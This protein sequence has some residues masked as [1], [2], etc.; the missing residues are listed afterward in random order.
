MQIFLRVAIALALL[1]LLTTTSGMDVEGF[2]RVAPEEVPVVAAPKKVTDVWAAHDVDLGLQ[3]HRASVVDTVGAVRAAD[4]S[5]VNAA[6][7]LLLRALEQ[8]DVQPADVARAWVAA[9]LEA[10]PHVDAP[11][12]MALMWPESRYQPMAGPACGVM[13]VY[14]HDIGLDDAS[15]C[16]LWK[17][18]VR[19]G[20]R[21]GV[22]E[23]ET[24][25]ADRRVHNLREAL[26]YRA[27]GNKA[28]TGECA[29]DGWV[30]QVFARR[31][32]LV[33]GSRPKV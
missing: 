24:M 10:T 20:V 28:F 16:A 7:A 5:R 18:D 21:A 23:I 6:F 19:A 27:C 2:H 3:A 30:D 11:L 17:R 33:G 25:L 1:A 12:L 31:A 13:Q 22:I 9:E 32:Y 4:H 29:M 8:P 15:S 26:L 14:P